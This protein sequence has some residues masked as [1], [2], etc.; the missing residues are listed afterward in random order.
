MCPSFT[1]LPQIVQSVS[2]DVMNITFQNYENYIVLTFVFIRVW[3]LQT[4]PIAAEEY[5]LSYT[6]RQKHDSK[7]LWL[8]TAF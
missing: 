1:I 2:K 8:G 5:C 4:D 7:G 3:N 6:V